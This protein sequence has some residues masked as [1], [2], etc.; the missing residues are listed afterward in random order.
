M[1]R[2]TI[3]LLRRSTPLRMLSRPVPTRDIPLPMPQHLPPATRSDVD[4]SLAL[5]YFGWITLEETRK[6]KRGIP[7]GISTQ[8]RLDRIR[9][10]NAL[11]INL[12]AAEIHLEKRNSILF[13]FLGI[14][15]GGTI[16]FS[17]N[18]LTLF[19]TLL[20]VTLVEKNF[21]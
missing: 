18:N 21:A 15:F 3:P 5:Q 11:P 10:E 4:R 12:L 6:R 8:E 16:H 2:P 14:N 20:V 19:F 17:L 7:C 9:H 13:Q 1:P